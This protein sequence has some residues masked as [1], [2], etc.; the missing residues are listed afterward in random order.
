MEKGKNPNLVECPNDLILVKLPKSPAVITPDNKE[1]GLK[2]QSI[3]P[4]DTQKAEPEGIAE[5]NNADDE[6]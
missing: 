4:P 6:N 2:V 3:P 5:G 1:T